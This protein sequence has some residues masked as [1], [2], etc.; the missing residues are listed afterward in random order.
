VTTGRNSELDERDLEWI[1]DTALLDRLA[2]SKKPASKKL[3][4]RLPYRELFKPAFRSPVLAPEERHHHNYTIRLEKFDQAG[5]LDPERRAG[6]E[7]DLARSA[8]VESAEVVLYCAQAPGLQKIQQYV[9]HSPGAAQLRDEAYRP[10]L[11][12]FERHLGLW[13]VY[14]FTSL[15]HTAPGF[16]RL[17]EASE[18]VF[19]LTNQVS[20]NRR[21]GL[22]F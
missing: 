2:Q 1:G 13:T 7:R 21:Q 10:Y 18:N 8:R 17:G 11:R 20:V 6:I 22:L 9:E 14:V 12:T 3:A 4:E 5:L 19:G 16:S 15:E